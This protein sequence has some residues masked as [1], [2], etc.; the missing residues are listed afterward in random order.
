MG[1]QEMRKKIDE[2]LDELLDRVEA[3]D[4]E[5]LDVETSEGIV[6]IEFEDG[7]K[8]IVSRQSAADQIWLAEP[9]NGWKFDCK[10]GKWICE[11]NS[12]ELFAMIETLISEKLGQTVKLH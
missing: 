9:R 6:T 1:S 12:K 8:L 10:D 3:I 2:T 4:N 5:A 11:K 7:V